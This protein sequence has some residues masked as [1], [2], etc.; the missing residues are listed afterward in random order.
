[1]L[2]N[3]LKKIFCDDSIIDLK[4]LEEFLLLYE[5]NDYIYPS[6]FKSFFEC[7]DEKTY[8]ILSNLEDND[9][10]KIIYIVECYDCERNV[11]V[12][13]NIWEIRNVVC[14]D[15]DRELFFPDN[16]KVAYKVIVKWNK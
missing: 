9:L 2:Q 10:V 3:L 1:M 16:V 4:K 13:E 12:F 11:E 5:I 15:C 8:E 7:S 6:A 14:G